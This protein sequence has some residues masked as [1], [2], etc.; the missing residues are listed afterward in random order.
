[1]AINPRQIE[2]FRAVVLTGSATAAAE[3]LGVTQ[4]AVSRLIRDLEIGLDL[5]LFARRGN[6]LVPLPEAVE[7]HVEV[8]RA[9]VGLDRIGQAAAA[10]RDR[11]A[12]TLRVAALPAMAT[13]FV[14]RVL[15]RFLADRPDVQAIVSGMPSHLVMEAVGAGQF[16]IGLAATPV[17]QPGFRLTPTAAAVVAVVPARHR[18]ARAR[19][20]TAADLADER[21]ISLGTGSLIRHRI[22][23]AC[24]GVPRR[25][26]IETPLSA[27]ACAM[28]AEGMGVTIV[29][30]FSA[31]EFRGRG[32]AIRRF[33]PNVEVGVA[34]IAPGQRPQ[35]ALGRDF[36]E[37][38]LSAIQDFAVGGPGRASR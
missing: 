36:A 30:P 13:G 38:L 18:L 4:P 1:M 2:A 24:A 16:D 35:S 15:G 31:E 8:D 3:M 7:L 19:S 23:M 29:D 5:P 9:F 28:V 21:F 20:V 33:L 11:R 17:E 26:M 34:L 25:M 27:I 37:A 22:D 12:G 14:P 10:L 32:V 6:R